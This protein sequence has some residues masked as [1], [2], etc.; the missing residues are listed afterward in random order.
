MT[1]PSF[2]KSPVG[3]T[4]DPVLVAG[5]TG[6]VGRRLAMRLR[7]SGTEVRCLARKPEA[8]ADL[9]AAGCEVVQGDILDPESLRAALDGTE[10]AYYLVHSMGRGSDGDFARR[11][12]EGAGNFA[13]AASGAGSG[14]II[15]LGG[16]GEATSE[17]LRSRMETAE[18]LA[19][20]NVPLTHLRAAVVIG[21][22]SESFRTIYWLVKRLPAMV[23]PRWTT[24]RTQPIGIDDVVE[25]LALSLHLQPA[26]D[27]E[28]EV[29]GPD[30]T[31]YGGMMDEVARAM[32]RRPPLRVRVP[33]LSPSLSARWIGLVT[34]VDTGVARPLVEGLTTETVVRD[35]SGMALFEHRPGSLGAAMRDAVAGMQDR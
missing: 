29:G 9:R 10:S 3:V 12:V 1:A 30:V 22:G 34:P 16:L 27:L 2:A 26:G 11:D 24:I 14:R 28:I 19:S 25:Y 17:H 32:G 4:A 33:V 35:P 13:E 7:A 5:A 20:G 8:A 31:T 15:Y 21:S 23:T 6:F 18:A